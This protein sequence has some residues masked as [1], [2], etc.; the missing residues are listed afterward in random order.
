MVNVQFITVISRKEGRKDGRQEGIYL[1]NSTLNE[2][3]KL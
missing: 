3:E 1:M 2:W